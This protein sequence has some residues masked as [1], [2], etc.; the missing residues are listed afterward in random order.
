MSRH[1]FMSLPHTTIQRLLYPNNIYSDAPFYHDFSRKGPLSLFT[2]YTFFDWK[3]IYY[4][5]YHKYEQAIFLCHSHTHT[6]PTPA[7]SN[8]KIFM[9]SL[10]LKRVW[11]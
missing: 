1:S 11:R 2:F 6:Y 8:H 5:E 7:L 10:L 4:Y 9:Q 3:Y